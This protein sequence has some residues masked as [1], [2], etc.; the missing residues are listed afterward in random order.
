MQIEKKAG[1]SVLI[2][3]KGGI[4]IRKHCKKQRRVLYYYFLI[5]IQVLYNVVLASNA[6]QNESAI[7]IHISPPFWI[8]LHLGHH[9]ALSRVPCAIQYVPLGCLFYTQYQ[10]CICVN[11]NLPIPPTP[12][13]FPLVSIHLFSTSVSLFLLC[14]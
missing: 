12:P 4:Q 9:R 6:Q 10:Q 2:S 1:V 3:D 5:G 7:H 11:P 13:L 8:S 14:K